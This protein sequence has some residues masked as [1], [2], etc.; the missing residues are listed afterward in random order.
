MPQ[1]VVTDVAAGLITRWGAVAALHAIVPSSAVFLGMRAAENTAYPYANLQ[2]TKVATEL[3]SGPNTIQTWTAKIDA[4]TAA[5]PA[6]AGTLAKQLLIAFAGASADPTNG[7]TVTDGT[8]LHIMED[9]G[10]TVT[11]TT[12]RVDGKDIIKVSGGF[13]LLVQTNRG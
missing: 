4:Y 3:T 5:E 7:I 11:Q 6:V 12:E 8:V 13:R 10:Q 2:V 1:T 9:P